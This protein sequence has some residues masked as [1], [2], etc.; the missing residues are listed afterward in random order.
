MKLNRVEKALMNNPVR[1]ALQRWYESPLLER[2]GGRLDGLRVLEVGCGHGVGT[3]LLFTRFGAREVVAF[4]VDPEMVAQARRRLAASPPHR[5]TL[6]VGDVTAIE[7]AD[8]ASDAVVDFGVIHHVPGWRAA[9]GEVRRVLRPGGRFFFEEVTRHALDRSAYCT[10]L[11]HPR[12]DRFTGPDYVAELERQNIAVGG[13]VVERF[14]GDFII[15]AGRRE[16]AA[17][18]RA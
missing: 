3:E 2:L 7:A 16:Q 4:D 8:G 12:E 17:G 18:G 1:A 13:S 14:F 15:G 9:V 6:R 11:D 10:F 5:L